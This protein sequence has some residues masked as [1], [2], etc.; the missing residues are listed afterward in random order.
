M[1]GRP[2][3]GHQ[4]RLR[5]EQRDPRREEESVHLQIRRQGRLTRAQEIRRRE[6]DKNDHGCRDSHARIEVPIVKTA[7]WAPERWSF[8]SHRSG[9]HF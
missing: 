5:D 6:S 4:R 7:D 9:P 8:D 3:R 1:H 2:S